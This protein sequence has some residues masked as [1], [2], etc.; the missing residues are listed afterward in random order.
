VRRVVLLALL[1]ALAAGCS[2]GSG[3]G[4]ATVWITRDRGARVLHVAEVPAGLTAMQA[5]SRVAKVKTRYGGRY[6]RSVDGVE[7]GDRRAWFYYVNGYLAD[8]GAADYVLHKGDV[9]WWDYRSWKDPAEYPVVVGAFPEPFLHGYAGKRRPTSILY[10]GRR[11]RR[12][13]K[14]LAR[15]LHAHFVAP[16]QRRQPPS[17]NLLLLVRRARVEFRQVGQATSPGAGGSVS[18]IF[19]GDPLEL[20]RHPRMFRFRYFVR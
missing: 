13:A 19:S 5:L 2:G 12:G 10:E 6:V 11:L 9:E 16:M 1:G 20:A 14:A 4:R 15:L 18:F 8:R 17:D 7:E 3:S